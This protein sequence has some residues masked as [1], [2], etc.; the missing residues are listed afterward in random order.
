MSSYII[1]ISLIFSLTI[2]P[3]N[4]R[5]AKNFTFEELRQQVH[6]KKGQFLILGFFSASD[7]DKCTKSVIYYYTSI[8]HQFKTHQFKLAGVIPGQR[9]AE[10]GV[11]KGFLN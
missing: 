1:L 7:C 5:Q 8:K 11:Y 3:S 6:L 2:G 4:A 9:D 10:L